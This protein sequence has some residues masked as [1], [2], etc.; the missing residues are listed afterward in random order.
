MRA[1]RVDKL[2]LAALE[3][4]LL[5]ALDGDRDLEHIPLW[6]F[7]NTPLDS[8]KERAEKLAEAFRAELGLAAACIETTAFL[9]GGSAPAEP[10][11]TAAIRVSP[12]FP[13]SWPSEHAWA[14]ALRSGDLPVI[15]RVHAGAV[16]FDLRAVAPEDDEALLDAVRQ[17]SVT[18][19]PLHNDTLI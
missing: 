4:T 19:K 13:L 2:T 15:P 10:I 3:A 7:L 16:L 6:A 12:P 1:L 18:P 17:V 9:G 5:L 11:P 8:L 14:R